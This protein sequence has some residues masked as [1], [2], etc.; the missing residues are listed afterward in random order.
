MLSLA[1]NGQ[2]PA[3]NDFVI[4][5]TIPEG[6]RP[7]Q[8]IITNFISRS[9]KPMSINIATNGAIG[10]YNNN[11]AIEGIICQITFTWVNGL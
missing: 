4:I 1:M 5:A 2:M 11:T 3:V 8:N 10:L 6:Y 9:G 7:T